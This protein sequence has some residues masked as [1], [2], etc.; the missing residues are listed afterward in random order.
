MKCHRN[1]IPAAEMNDV[2]V[3][4]SGERPSAI[5]ASLTS[6]VRTPDLG[7]AA[8]TAEVA[9]AVLAHLRRGTT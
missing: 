5:E 1:G 9:D 4:N 3:L 2:A 8:T 7:G 6:G